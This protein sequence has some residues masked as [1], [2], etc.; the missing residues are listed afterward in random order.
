VLR[1]SSKGEGCRLV[2]TSGE[3]FGSTSVFFADPEDPLVWTADPF[4]GIGETVSGRLVIN[5]L[6][7]DVSN[8]SG[9]VDLGEH[10]RR[11][12]VYI[13]GNLFDDDIP[14]E[15]E[16]IGECPLAAETEI[17]TN[18]LPNG[19]HEVW[20]VATDKNGNELT[21]PKLTFV[22]DNDT[23]NLK[24]LFTNPDLGREIDALNGGS[25]TVT[26][27]FKEA[28][29]WQLVAKDLD[30]TNATSFCYER[31]IAS[32]SGTSM[33]TGWNGLLYQD[34]RALASQPDLVYV[35]LQTQGS[36][37]TSGVSTQSLSPGKT[38][39]W[40]GVRTIPDNA[41]QVLVS[42]GAPQKP[43]WH[44]DGAINLWPIRTYTFY[45]RAREQGWK[46]KRL[47][48]SQSNW[49]RWSSI[50]GN[51]VCKMVYHEGH[52][53]VWPIGPNGTMQTVFSLPGIHNGVINRTRDIVTSRPV[54]GYVDIA[55]LG[56]EYS[57]RI[58]FFQLDT[59]KSGDVG[60]VLSDPMRDAPRVPD[61]RRN[62]MAKVLGVYYDE[63]EPAC[64]LGWYGYSYGG[65]DYCNY[66]S[67]VNPPY[68]LHQ[69]W[70]STYSQ[71]LYRVIGNQYPY[72]WLLT[73]S[74]APDSWNKIHSTLR[75]FGAG[76]LGDNM[77]FYELMYAL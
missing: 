51:G 16:S 52:G 24:Y 3:G 46:T 37:S 53:N 69:L 12:T 32:G 77:G 27:S 56:L 63:F 38:G 45:V 2:A 9:N 43:D 6:L 50:V 70:C 55:S 22:S 75:A 39:G 19:T 15:D 1:S 67:S 60:G 48:P 41:V 44:D 20:C 73:Q 34:G 65:E 36:T 62:D 40:I 61:N 64:Y 57:N 30:P 28:T 21:S 5:W 17:I 13:D 71:I 14:A 18:E 23:S 29:S 26:A 72:P 4:C 31:V 58:K 42:V 68:G 25:M 59:C 8:T 49:P 7:D 35:E 76:L 66:I 47:S 11:Y 10:L 54:G 33:N 74:G